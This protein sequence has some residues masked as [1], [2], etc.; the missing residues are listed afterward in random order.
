MFA[1]MGAAF[2]RLGLVVTGHGVAG[3]G[4]LPAATGDGHVD[5]SKITAIDTALLALFEDI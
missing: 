1:R 5:F 3:G 2:G 4:S